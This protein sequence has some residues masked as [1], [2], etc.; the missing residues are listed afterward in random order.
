MRSATIAAQDGPL[1]ELEPFLG[2]VRERL[3][4]DRTLQSGY[5]YVEKR[6]ELK[7]DKHGRA[8]GVSEKVF[9]SYRVFRARLHEGASL[10][11][12]RRK[13]NGEV[14]LPAT[15]VYEWSARLGLVRVVRLIELLE[16]VTFTGARVAGAGS[17]DGLS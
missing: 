15:A 14:W 6:R 7:L 10:A 11:F 2:E 4:T 9:E 16:D 1:P 12:M 5:T 8:T 17:R 3:Q 13:I